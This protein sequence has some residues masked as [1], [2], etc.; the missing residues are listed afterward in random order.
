MQLVYQANTWEN[1]VFI[2]EILVRSQISFRF[3]SHRSQYEIYVNKIEVSGV[4]SL[5]RDNNIKEIDVK[6]QLELIK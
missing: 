4:E 3:I 5:I 1:I 6:T 2:C